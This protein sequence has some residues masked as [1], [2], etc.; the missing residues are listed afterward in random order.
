MFIA[1]FHTNFHMP[2][3]NGSLIMAV[4]LKV[5]YKYNA[6]NMLL[7]ILEGTTQNIFIFSMNFKR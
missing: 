6:V 7:Y 2:N 1:N 3:Y 4:K 5:K